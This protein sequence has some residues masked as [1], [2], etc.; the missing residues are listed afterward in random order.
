MRGY[1]EFL[2][3]KAEQLRT[4]AGGA[5]EI[6]EQLRRLAEDLD[7]TAAELSRELRGGY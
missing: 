5:P 3:Q 4:I 7:E 1:I 2:H 6:A